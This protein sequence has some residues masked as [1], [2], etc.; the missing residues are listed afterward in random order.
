[1]KDGRTALNAK[2]CALNPDDSNKRICDFYLKFHSVRLLITHLVQLES[3]VGTYIVLDEEQHSP[4]D[5]ARQA[6]TANP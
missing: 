3:M 5:Q 4:W 6:Q 1:M 2:F